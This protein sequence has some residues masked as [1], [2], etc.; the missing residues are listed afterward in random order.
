MKN[1]RLVYSH[2]W[3]TYGSRSSIRISY[4]LHIL[5]RAGRLIALP[6]VTSYIIADL[7][8][9]DF[10]HA[11]E[12]VLWFIAISL[13]L[14]IATPL[15]KYIGLHGEE[16]EYKKTTQEYFSRLLSTDLEYFN[17]NL[18]GY[19]TTATRQYV[20][21]CLTLVRTLRD[22]YLNTILSIVFPLAVIAWLDW[23]LG[24]ITFLL[25]F[26]ICMY[27][28]WASRIID[29][30]RT[31]SRE[32]YRKNSG[33]IADIVSNILAVK[34][35]AQENT[36]KE[37]VRT[38]IGIEGAVFSARFTKQAKL[39]GVRECIALVF[40]LVLLWTTV[41]RLEDGA[42]TIEGAILIVTYT[43]VILGGIYTLS[44]DVDAH[45]DFVDKIIPAF[46]ILNRTNVIGDPADPIEFTSPTRTIAFQNVSFSYPATAGEPASVLTNFSLHI[47]AGQ[48]VGVVGLSGAG[49]S[50]L[51]KLLMRFNDVTE[52]SIEIEGVDV[53]H[54]T[55][56]H[57]RSHIAYVPQEPLLF[58][59]SIRENV[60]LARPSASPEEIEHALRTAHA[61]SFVQELPHGIESIVGERGVKLSGGQKQRI[62]I[63]RALLQGAPI[64]ILDEATSALDSESE[65]I[66]KDAFGE[67]LKDKTAIVVAHRLS[68]LS[69]MDRIIVIHDGAITED[70][71]HANLLSAGGLYAQLWKR[72]HV[73]TG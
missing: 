13:F 69:H 5:V 16:E 38:A 9:Q 42:L 6:I 44:E 4:I 68:T 1:Y 11:R 39:I 41:I 48:K 29:P 53:R 67:I 49:K 65:H 66:I 73:H 54:V 32:L 51:T 55:Q 24:I 36:Y 23:Q 70:G 56:E 72:Q 2:L 45:D 20:D 43:T 46:S 25:S 30:Y 12:S 33:R 71:T 63:A 27:L 22:R 3:R 62:A 64:I 26:F 18:S 35:A 15:V 52:G 60:L 58:H 7:A 19:L 31:K 8:R 10:V 37:E 50:T 40:F 21:S 47:P 61:W 57:L 59:A 34:S 17:S 28:I 14:G